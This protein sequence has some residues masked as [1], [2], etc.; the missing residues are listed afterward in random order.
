M[1]EVAIK[2]VL[3]NDL[4]REKILKLHPENVDAGAIEDICGDFE[5]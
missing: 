4:N 1:I 2:S 3:D 5:L